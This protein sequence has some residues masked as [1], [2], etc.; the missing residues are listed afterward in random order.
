MPTCC[1]LK[2]YLL[3]AGT[4]TLRM[5]EDVV[6]GSDVSSGEASRQG[7]AQP[8]TPQGDS[9]LRNKHTTNHARPALQVLHGCYYVWSYFMRAI[10]DAHLSC[11]SENVP[12]AA[13]SK[14]VIEEQGLGSIKDM[15]AN[16]VNRFTDK[17]LDD[18]K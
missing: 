9:L 13:G 15:F 17:Y 5:D 16:I 7:T 3:A 4:V 1:R 10:A 6:A 2:L 11:F 14:Q 12:S 8:S 18:K